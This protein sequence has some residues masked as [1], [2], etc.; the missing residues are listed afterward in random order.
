M[1]DRRYR[2]Q[3]Y[4]DSARPSSSRETPPG[5]QASGWLKSH[6]ISRC[7]D[8]GSALPIAVDPGGRCPSCKAELHACIQCAHFDPGRRWEC[9]ESI[10][11]RI[12]D[13]RARNGC[14]LFSLRVTVERETSSASVRPDDA[15]RAFDGLFKKP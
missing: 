11:E 15:R 14:A 12:T 6:N 2:Q 7:A 4:K 8:C 5:P 1:E 3:G 13:K 10:P 9:T